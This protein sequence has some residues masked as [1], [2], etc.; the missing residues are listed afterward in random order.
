MRRLLQGRARLVA[1]LSIAAL[2]AASI[3][4]VATYR[5]RLAR[6]VPA[7]DPIA[8]Q[9]LAAAKAQIGTR[10]DGSYRV[11]AYLGGDV[12]ARTGACTDIVIRSLRGAGIDLQ[13]R[14]HDDMASDR[15]AY[16]R[17]GGA[18]LDTSIDHRR[19]P[20]VAR[21]PS[22]HAASLPLASG[23]AQLSEWRPCDI[24][25]W[26]TL[27]GR[28]HIGIISDGRDAEGAPFVIHN[29]YGCVEENCLGR[30]KIVGHYRIRNR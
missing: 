14:V 6:R 18:S 29:E 24:V 20:N 2:V 28:D 4:A 8:A 13:E 9:I 16:P 15:A 30:W 10:Y 7:A 23:P 22:R 5:H 21:C 26:K 12:P 1:F 3:W 11:I 17:Y 27:F 19:V 25:C